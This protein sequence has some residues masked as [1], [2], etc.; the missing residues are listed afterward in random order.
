MT[1][2]RPKV[3]GSEW[4]IPPPRRKAVT[5]FR[6]R[7][8]VA[9]PV[10]LLVASFRLRRIV[11]GD[12][13]TRPAGEG[14]RCEMPTGGR[15]IFHH[16]DVR[17]APERGKELFAKA[18]VRRD[19]RHI[20]NRPQANRL[21]VSRGSQPPAVGRECDRV[22]PPRVAEEKMRL[23]SGDG[24]HANDAKAAARKECC[25]RIQRELRSVNVRIDVRDLSI[26]DGEPKGAPAAV[27][28]EAETLRMTECKARGRGLKL[29]HVLRRTV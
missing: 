18:L 9:R 5:R 16:A 28:R 10:H 3:T 12:G 14:I 27:R 24:P 1:D 15:T 6:N 25:L 29:R 7:S 4:T 21:V 8:A 20:G 2:R 13:R 11:E 22:D 17:R 23:G 26:V 19:L